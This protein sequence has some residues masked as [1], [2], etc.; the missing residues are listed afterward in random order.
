MVTTLEHTPEQLVRSV[1]FHF[2]PHVSERI[3]VST[4]NKQVMVCGVELQSEKPHGTG[5][6]S[7]RN[8][9]SSIRRH[10]LGQISKC[11]V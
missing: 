1:C 3:A 2:I 5:V 7:V 6:Q 11:I 9:W 4:G 8:N 10:S